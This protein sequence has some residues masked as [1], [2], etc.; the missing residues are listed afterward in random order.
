MIYLPTKKQFYLG[1]RIQTNLLT[2]K[3]GSLNLSSHTGIKLSYYFLIWKK[4]EQTNIQ[5]IDSCQAVKNDSIN[6]QWSWKNGN[7]YMTKTY[8]VRSTEAVTRESTAQDRAGPGF[9]PQAEVFCREVMHWVLTVLCYTTLTECV[10]LLTH[11]CEALKEK[12]LSEH[13]EVIKSKK[14]SIGLTQNYLR[15]KV[16]T[17]LSEESLP[18][19]ESSA[20]P[21]NPI[22]LLF[23]IPAK[24]NI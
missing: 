1:A 15:K 5:A 8:W 17:I 16:D 24:G 20:W 22:F 6:I 19:W 23:R 12:G 13:T 3:T 9:S 11:E 21:K 2:I 14:Q 7:V 18:L 4:Y 10:I